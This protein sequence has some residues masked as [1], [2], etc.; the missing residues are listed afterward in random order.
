MSATLKYIE[1][2]TLDLFACRT[3]FEG[4][5]LNANLGDAVICTKSQ[6]AQGTCMGD[7]GGPLVDVSDPNNKVLAGVVSW[8][9]PVS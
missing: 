2:R 4:K 3:R 8:G 9:V 5:N 6:Y 7:S 1:I